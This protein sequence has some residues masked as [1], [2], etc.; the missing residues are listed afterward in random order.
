MNTDKVAVKRQEYFITDGSKDLKGYPR[1]WGTMTR[2][3]ASNKPYIVLDT[4]LRNANKMN[5][6]LA[7]KEREI[8]SR[9][10]NAT[11][12]RFY[13]AC[14]DKGALIPV[15]S[16]RSESAIAREASQKV[17]RLSD[18]TEIEKII[19]MAIREAKS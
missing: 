5:R 11:F 2:S 18:P 4:A 12:Q 9:G 3:M 13:V 7:A 17:Y 19:L 8:A 6:E 14:W 15:Q 10:G 16:D 1:T